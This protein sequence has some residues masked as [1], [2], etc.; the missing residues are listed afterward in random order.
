MDIASLPK[1]GIVPFGW[2]NS[3]DVE[4]EMMENGWARF[5]ARDGVGSTLQ[6]H[7][8]VAGATFWLS[9]SNHI[10]KRCHITSNFENYA[11]VEGVNFYVEVSAT[12]QEV[13]EGF[14][15]LCPAD[16]F[17]AGPSSWRW[18][19]CPAYWS[20]EPSGAHPL[21]IDEA[22]KLGFPTLQ[23]RT[24]ARGYSWD[25]SV[26]AGLAKFYLAKGFDPYS[27]DVAR[28]LGHP[29]YRLAGE[30]DPVFAHGNYL[31]AP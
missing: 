29:L 21:R 11:V 17:R 20:L 25:S 18:P 30:I 31:P 14:L 26:Y 5:N 27:Q 4:G 1:E 19:T 9:Q 28:H 10:F 12:A 24:E 8:W 15:F 16:V 13:P 22:M 3:A 23:F 7:C 6:L 2:S